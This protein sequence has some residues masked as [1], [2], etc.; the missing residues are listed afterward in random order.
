MK[1]SLLFGFYE[2]FEDITQERYDDVLGYI[3]L[4]GVFTGDMPD[5]VTDIDFGDG[6]SWRNTILV[7]QASD[8]YR[9]IGVELRAELVSRPCT[10]MRE[11]SDAYFR[12]TDI[13]IDEFYG[14]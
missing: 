3:A 8:A 11:S 7:K 6:Y 12:I 9:A 10:P 4:H 5:D 14:R 13:E 2:L 1:Q